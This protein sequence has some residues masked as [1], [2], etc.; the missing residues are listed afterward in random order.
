M[1]VNPFMSLVELF[2]SL[3]ILCFLSVSLRWTCKGR[4]PPRPLQSRLPARKI[5]ASRCPQLIPSGF[6][7]GRDPASVQAAPS[8]HIH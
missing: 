5:A 2:R 6:R 8:P 7:V 3:H 1:P 4:S